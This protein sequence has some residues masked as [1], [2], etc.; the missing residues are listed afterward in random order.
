VLNRIFA[1]RYRINEKIGIGGMAEVYKATDE[2]LGR[3]VAIKVMLPQ[4]AADPSFAARFK[5]EAQAAANLQ[6]PY[7]V[8]IYDWGHD[9]VDN[10]YYIV[11]EYVRGTDLKT[12]IQQRGAIN[13]RKVAE[14]GSQVCA[15]LGVAHSYDIIHRDIKPH[16]IM[17]QPDGNAKVMDFGIARANNSQMTQTGSVLGTAYYVSPEQAQGKPL[18]A[19]TDIYSLGV[20]LYEATTGQVPFEGPD[21]VSIAVKQVNETPVLPSEINPEIDACLEAIILKAMAK[22]PA[23]RF[24][25]AEQMRAA[26]NDYLAGR[27]SMLADPNAMTNVITSAGSERTVSAA[28][29][30]GAR[31]A[32]RPNG[33]KIGADG[34][35]LRNETTVMPSVVKP[36]ANVGNGRSG[37]NSTAIDDSS[38]TGKRIGIAIALVAVL[39]VIVIGVIVAYNIMQTPA[40]PSDVTVPHVVSDTLE[41]AKRKLEAEGLVVGEVKEQASATVKAGFII[42]QDPAAASKVEVGTKVNLVISTGVNMVTVPDLVN[43]TPAEAEKALSDLKLVY[44]KGLDKPHESIEIG[45]I[46]GQSAAAGSEVAE[47]TKIVC[48]IS[49]GPDSITIP[50]VFGMTKEAADNALR[51]AGFAVAYS[52]E[53]FSDTINSGSVIRQDRTGSAKKGDTITLTISKGPKPPDP[54]P[55]VTV[56][57]VVG[58]SIDAANNALVNVGLVLDYSAP[59]SAGQTVVT[60]NPLAGSQ[61]DKGTIVSVTFGG[62]TTGGTDIAG[63]GGTGGSGST[64][65]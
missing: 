50:N 52:E 41:D 54:E 3:T 16:N 34:V 1:N 65:Y 37:R 29:A 15:A 49:S 51:E 21:P 59:P 60:Q 7:I 39:A 46:S 27:A 12:A 57:N 64:N 8:N 23:E 19:S 35:S 40:K 13:Q 26:L 32:A 42:S 9:S 38:S 2:V 53:E 31:L 20:V 14:I 62:G 33:A 17:V 45:R 55:Q 10:T 47:G 36:I 24:A 58:M 63:G 48:E 22:N 11:M 25:T 6:S 30:A 44:S 5:Q 43:M 4:Y 28:G 18:T 61:V 56:P